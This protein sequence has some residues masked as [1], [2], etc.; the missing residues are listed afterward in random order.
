MTD[1]KKNFLLKSANLFIVRR[2]VLEYLRT[3]EKDRKFSFVEIE[4]I[5]DR[6]LDY[7]E[8]ALEIIVNNFSRQRDALIIDRYEHLIMYMYEPAF[9]K[10]LVPLGFKKNVY[11]RTSLLNLLNFYGFNLYQSPYY[12][13]IEG[14]YSKVY[15]A[16]MVFLR[17]KDNDLDDVKNFLKDFYFLSD[18]EKARL[19]EI[20]DGSSPQKRYFLYNVLI[21]TGFKQVLFEIIRNLGK[22]KSE[23]A[24]FLLNFLK[25]MLPFE[26]IELIDKALSKSMLSVINGCYSDKSNDKKYYYK[27]MISDLNKENSFLLFF[28][29]RNHNKPVKFLFNINE[30]YFLS[31]DSYVY[32]DNESPI[33]KVY[34]LKEIKN[35]IAFDILADVLLNHFEMEVPLPWQFTYFTCFVDIEKILPKSYTSHI[36]LK[37]DFFI[38]EYWQRVFDMY[39]Q[40]NGWFMNENKFCNILEKWY[41]N[42]EPYEDIWRDHLFLRKIIREVILPEINFWIKRFYQLADYLFYAES[43]QKL[44][45]LIYKNIQN[46]IPDVESIEKN[47]FIKK[48]IMYNKDKCLLEMRRQR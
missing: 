1:S 21:W 18:A 8:Y 47:S 7:G 41:Y 28:E 6:L 24:I 35:E 31:V 20:I 15:E 30:F 44:A 33:E 5:A 27:T 9:L 13:E 22:R 14:F 25:K 34:S 45:F 26:Y 19:I 2:K 42:T 3:I 16:L 43:Q 40:E 32:T 29:V 23:R 17:K 46:L 12:G 36:N 37:E 11:I 48:L 4:D 39:V 38:N 10:Y